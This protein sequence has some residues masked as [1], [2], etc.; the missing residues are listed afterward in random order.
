LKE[1]GYFEGKSIAL[2]FRWAE[3]KLDRLPTLAAELVQLP[4]DVLIT[5]GIPATR[6]AKA[7]TTTVPIVM[8]A[9]GD[10]VVMGLVT[11]LARPGG[12]SWVDLRARARREALS[13]QAGDATPAAWRSSQPRQPDPEGSCSG[14]GC[15]RG[16]RAGSSSSSPRAPSGLRRRARRHSKKPVGAVV[17]IEE[18][19]Q[20][21]NARAVGARR[22]LRCLHR[23]DGVRFLQRPDCLWRQFPGLTGAPR[24]LSTDPQGA[25][26]GD[27]PVEQASRF[28]LV[29]RRKT[30]NALG[31]TIPWPFSTALIG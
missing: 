27:L 28:D 23:P 13:Y 6:A 5:Q 25:K 16:R 18:P 31:V 12:T 1:L 24:F 11:N 17:F 20:L 19:M 21:V 26:P 29:I 8:A 3:G 2:E 10:A 14:S 7:A 4:V 22:Q 30:A 15:E 9:V